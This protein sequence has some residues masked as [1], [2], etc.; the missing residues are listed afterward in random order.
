MKEHLKDLLHHDLDY[1]YISLTHIPVFHIPSA[2]TEKYPT[3]CCLLCL[4]KR[5]LPNLIYQ[6]PIP[7]LTFFQTYVYALYVE[8]IYWKVSGVRMT[9]NK[10]DELGIE[11]FRRIS[12]NDRRMQW[13][14]AVV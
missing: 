4:S 12:P 13:F 9:D 6:I 8:G 3:S 11:H 14:R 5:Y 10:K 7:Y 2:I 1:T